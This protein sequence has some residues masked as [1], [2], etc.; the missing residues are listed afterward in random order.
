VY[1]LK[2]KQFLF[3]NEIVETGIAQVDE[4]ILENYPR[5]RISLDTVNGKFLNNEIV[6]VGNS[7][8]NA[9]AHAIV[10]DFQPNS[11]L[12]VYRVTGTFTAGS[13]RGV[14][15]GATATILLA[16]DTYNLN[17]TFEDIVDN[18]RIQTESNAVIDWTEKNPFGET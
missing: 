11:H 4:Q 13:I 5:T 2:I 17:N 1:A 15:S 10:Y 12:D 7:L 14:D 8:A 3:S 18:A 16:D 6:Y 9:V